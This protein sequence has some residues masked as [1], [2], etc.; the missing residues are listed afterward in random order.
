MEFFRV[1]LKESIFEKITLYFLN[2]NESNTIDPKTDNYFVNHKEEAAAIE[3]SQYYVTQIEQENIANMELL[4]AAVELQKEALWNR[5]KL[6]DKLYV[7]KLL[8]DD[9]CKIQLW[10]QVVI[11][12]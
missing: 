10:R 4:D 7:R 8:E 12:N 5:L 6:G 9:S 3:A 2:P 11:R 1:F